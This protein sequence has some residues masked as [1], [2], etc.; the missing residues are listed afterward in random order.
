MQCSATRVKAVY[1]YFDIGDISILADFRDIDIAFSVL[2]DIRYISIYCRYLQPVSVGAYRLPAG[3]RGLL[4]KWLAH[5]MSVRE[6]WVR[7]PGSPVL[8]SFSSFMHKNMHTIGRLWVSN[9]RSL[10]SEASA[11]SVTPDDRMLQPSGRPSVRELVLV[12]VLVLK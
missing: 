8:H 9:P 4:A 6:P 10:V 2:F 1:R 11:L 12:L 7:C 5:G 3:G